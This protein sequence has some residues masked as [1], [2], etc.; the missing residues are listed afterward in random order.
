M[1]IMTSKGYR[2]IHVNPL[3]QEAAAESD[4]QERTRSAYHAAL[5]RPYTN[6]LSETGGS[7]GLAHKLK[8][9]LATA[10]FHRI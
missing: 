5:A 3:I 9:D 8:H 10:L 7:H 6:L 2:P 4:R 1:H